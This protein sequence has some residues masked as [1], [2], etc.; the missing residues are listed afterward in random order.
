MINY[1]QRVYLIKQQKKKINLSIN[2][3]NDAINIEN[4]LLEYVKCRGGT[5][6]R[7]ALVNGTK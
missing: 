5:N 1:Y 6:Q 7:L 2:I 4:D 3:N